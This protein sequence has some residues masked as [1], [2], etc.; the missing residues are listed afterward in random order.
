M[1]RWCACCYMEDK[2]S[3]VGAFLELSAVVKILSYYEV[4]ALFEWISLTMPLS[5][6]GRVSKYG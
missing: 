6:N 4:R 3:E 1:P 2:R 5:K